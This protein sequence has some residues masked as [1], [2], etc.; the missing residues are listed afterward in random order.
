MSDASPGSAPSRGPVP[1]LVVL[2]ASGGTALLPNQRWALEKLPTESGAADVTLTSRFE[3]AGLADLIARELVLEVR[4]PAHHAEQAVAQA[5]SLGANL[6]PLLSFAVNAHVP[7]PLPHLA[8]EAAPRLTRRRFWQAQVTLEQGLPR[9]SR[10]QREELLFPLLGAVFA[11]GVDPRLPRAFGQYHAA[12]RD[13][14]TSGRPLAMAH[15][16]MALEALGP[17]AEREA[18][19]RLNLPDQ[20]AH[21][22]YRGVDVGLKNWKEVLLGWV[23]RDELCQGDKVTYDLARR[24]SDGLEH[25]SMDFPEVRAAAETTGPLLLSYVRRGLLGL[26]DLPESVRRALADKQP[27]DVSPLRF[28]VTGELTGAVEDPDALGQDGQP[29]PYADWHVTLDDHHRLPDG[30]MRMTPRMNLTAR[31]AEDVQLTFT[32]HATGVG[33]TDPDLFDYEPSTEEPVVIRHQGRLGGAPD[34]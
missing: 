12:L 16:Y 7:V 29:Y 17:V 26:L 27:L 23:R 4:C 10:I 31:L 30:R 33:L 25:G 18:R 13:W 15:L 14:T 28:S 21:A 34:V 11:A 6:V 9:P 1:W 2:L 8:Y 20:Q 32:A 19:Q 24:A 5:V 22:R 3:D